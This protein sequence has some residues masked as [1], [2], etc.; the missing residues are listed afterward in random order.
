MQARS[1]ESSWF[2]IKTILGINVFG[3]RAGEYAARRAFEVGRPNVDWRKIENEYKRVYGILERTPR[4]PIRV[5]EVRHRLQ[6][7]M[8]EKAGPLKS[9]QDLKLAL[10]QLI[11]MRRDEL[12]RMHVISKSRIYNIEWM[13]ALETYN[14]F[15]TAELMLN[16]S[17]LRKES[18]GSY[19]REDY[20]QI[21][22]V[23]WLKNIHIKKTK[24]KKKVWK[25][26]LKVAEVTPEQIRTRSM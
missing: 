21:D 24:G 3:R 2:S 22:N 10:K 20:P 19:L 17:F 5:H 6:K 23:N 18:R 8:W 4:K 26:P 12:A 15:D 11:K 13:E 16:A 7:M 1:S 9:G 14:M 25:A